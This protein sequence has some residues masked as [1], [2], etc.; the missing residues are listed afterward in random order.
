M[1]QGGIYLLSD[2]GHEGVQELEDAGEHIRQHALR[3]AVLL[4]VLCG[5]AGFG[6]LDVP[7]AVDIPCEVVDRGE[8]Y[9]HLKFFK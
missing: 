4:G 7:V 6:K 5:K 8:R 2:E 3:R 9:A 1:R